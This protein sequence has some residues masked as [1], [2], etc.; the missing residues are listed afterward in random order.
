MALGAENNGSSNKTGKGDGE[1]EGLDGTI[2]KPAALPFTEG[3]R[4][5]MNFRTPANPSLYGG[6]VGA[7]SARGEHVGFDDGEFRFFP[8]D[9]A[10]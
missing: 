2:P 8:T 7:V 1:G 10:V 3:A 9:E 5:Q 6:V 4:V